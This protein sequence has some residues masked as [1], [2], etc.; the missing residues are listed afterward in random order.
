MTASTQHIVKSF[1]EQLENLRDSVVRMGGLVEAQLSGSIESLTKRDCD[2]AKR[3]CDNDDAVDALEL[4]IDDAAVRLLAL[5]QPMA[6]DLRE[7]MSAL[8]IASDLERIGDL[9]VNVARRT[10]PLTK[11]PYMPP[12]RTTARL[13]R[14]VQGNIKDTIDAYVAQDAE[15]SIELWHR[16]EEV[17]EMYTELV[18]ALLTYMMED[19]RNITACTHLMF[20]AKNI[21]RMGDHATNIAEAIYYQVTGLQIEVSKPKGE[22]GR[23]AGFPQE[24]TGAKEG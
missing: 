20:A 9:A 8:K 24:P 23:F 1:D 13:A 5:R 18:R 22:D 15:I 12:T 19:P 11:M 14:L 16:D 17:D 3:V 4:S 7:V 2:L 6:T 21:E 10:I